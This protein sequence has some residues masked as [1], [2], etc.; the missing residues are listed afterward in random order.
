MKVK[1]L[2]PFRVSHEG[3]IYKPGDSADVPDHLAAHWLRSEW[4]EPA[5]AAAKRAKAAIAAEL[6]GRATQGQPAAEAGA[7]ES[8]PAT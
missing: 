3:T 4:V 1:V 7:D 8:E 2:H 5:D 6:E